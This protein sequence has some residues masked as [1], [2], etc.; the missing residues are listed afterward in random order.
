MIAPGWNKIGRSGRFRQTV[1]FL[2]LMTSWVIAGQAHARNASIV[3]DFDTGRVLH[4]VNPDTRNYPASLTKMMT[5]YMAFDTI[6]KGRLKLDQQLR[7]SARAAA[8]RPSK[9]GLTAG[10]TISAHDAILAMMTKSAND[11]AVVVAEAIGGSE[12]KFSEMMTRK[13]RELGM[14]RTNFRNASGLPNR[15]QLS[16]ARDMAVLAKHLLT[17]FP[18]R[19]R[20]FSTTEFEFDGRVYRN[21]NALLE[22]Y[23]GVDGLKTGYTHAS[24]YNLVVSAKRDGHRVVG[25]IFGGQSSAARNSR[26]ERLL[27][28]AFSDL[29]VPATPGKAPAMQVASAATSTDADAATGEIVMARNDA[30]HKPETPAV[31]S[32]GRKAGWGIQVGAFTDDAP[33]RKAA[34]TAARNL[35]KKTRKAAQ[36]V[37]VP[38]QQGEET[39][40]RARLVGLSRN[41]ATAAC[42]RLQSRKLSCVPVPPGAD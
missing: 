36:V 32:T 13:A 39:I 35:T 41:T 10:S 24:G 37:V 14:T 38:V 17:D 42:R 1:I 16:T 29:N 9:L 3:V 31:Q 23:P 22:S 28:T 11:A 4:A 33:A 15:R 25:V 5:L 19:Y 40:Y 20:L 18:E 8:A 21:H 7:V 6:G 2:A 27:D 12:H 26:M 30:L 34:T